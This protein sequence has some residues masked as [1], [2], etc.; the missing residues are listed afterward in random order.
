MNIARRS[1]QGRRWPDGTVLKRFNRL[2]EIKSIGKMIFDP[3]WARKVHISGANE[4]LHVI[5]GNVNLRIGKSLIKACPGDTL[6]VPSGKMHRDD[7]DLSV[8]LEV[9]LFFFDWTPSKDYFRL[10][11]FN[12]VPRL[13][14]P[15]SDEIGRLCDRMQIGL[16]AGT[17]T[18]QLLIGSYAHNILLLILREA[19]RES[20]R[21][22]HEDRLRHG[23]ALLIK[24]REYIDLHYADQI[25]LDQIAA[26]LRISP[27]YLSHLFSREGGFSF[28]EYITQVRMRKARDMISGG[29]KN[30]SEAAYAVGYHDGS[31]FSKVFHRYYGLS[32][33]AV[34]GKTSAVA[35]TAKKYQK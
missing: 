33:N 27:F 31:Y 17:P 26:T 18:D 5:R 12:D 32:P 20:G 8:G 4:F 15:I 35:A 28:V 6:F 21:K 25:S 19:L 13:C 30:V 29:M 11:P 14:A 7:F 9:F 10:V 22:S 2:P 3:V 16:E 23:R 1:N 24:A 34:L